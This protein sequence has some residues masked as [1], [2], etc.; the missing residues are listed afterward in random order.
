MTGKLSVCP[1][2]CIDEAFII[3]M[4][5]LPELSAGMGY[6]ISA[7]CSKVIGVNGLE[8]NPYIIYAATTL[9]ILPGWFAPKH[10][11]QVPKH[12]IK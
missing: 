2:L 1:M 8:K 4:N 11:K 10:H 7:A 6:V 12:T 5:Y 3:W 9:A